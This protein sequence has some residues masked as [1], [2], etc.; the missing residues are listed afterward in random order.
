VAGLALLPA[1]Q[2]L[3]VLVRLAP[4]RILRFRDPLVARRSGTGTAAQRP[5][6]SPNGI[7]CSVT[8]SGVGKGAERCCQRLEQGARPDASS[9]VLPPQVVRSSASSRTRTAATSCARSTVTVRSMIAYEV[10]K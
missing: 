4:G 8:K 7:S 9:G 1:E 10:S 3:L 2:A 5:D 6:R